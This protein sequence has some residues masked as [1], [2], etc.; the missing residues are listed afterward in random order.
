MLCQAYPDLASTA[1]FRDYYDDNHPLYCFLRP[2]SG[3]SPT[4]F[5]VTPPALR[6]FPGLA[7]LHRRLY[8]TGCTY[9]E[10]R[11]ALCNSGLVIEVDIK[12]LIGG[13]D[14][15]ANGSDGKNLLG[16][17]PA[18]ASVIQ[19]VVGKWLTSMMFPKSSLDDLFETHKVKVPMTK[20]DSLRS[21]IR[22][23]SSNGKTGDVRRRN[24]SLMSIQSPIPR[25]DRRGM[26]LR[27]IGGRQIMYSHQIEHRKIIPSGERVHV[28]MDVSGSMTE[29]I[30]PL[31]GAIRDCWDWVFPKVHL[32]STIVSD[33]T[34]KELAQGKVKS[35][36][37]TDI[38]CVVRHMQENKV[39]RAVIVTDGHVGNASA[40]ELSVLNS[41]F[42]G[43]A[44]TGPEASRNLMAGYV[45]VWIDITGGGQ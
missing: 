16:V 3:W 22:K 38:S 28:Y 31:Y 14:D 41:V 20:R 6:K 10:L 12:V 17:A 34:L 35:N 2:A 33:I 42:I 29:F 1:L 37:G 7:W 15:D 44:L 45:N 18:L 25:C 4:G 13:H 26:V 8:K 39:Q 40:A 9:S 23:V 21:L 27:A 43:T 32:F 24:L 36:S 30:P 11:E 19:K 5:A